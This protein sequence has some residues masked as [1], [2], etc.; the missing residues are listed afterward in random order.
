[1]NKSNKFLLL[2]FLP[3]ILTVIFV[4]YV[5][6]PSFDSLKNAKSD[7]ADN[8]TKLNELK[9]K[10]AG[11]KNNK[12]NLLVI[13][14]LSQKLANF[15]QQVSED[16]DSALLVF[17]SEKLADLSK[18]QLL[19][20]SIKDELSEEELPILTKNNSPS[21]TLPKAKLT[22]LVSIPVEI[23]IQGNYL[24]VID[25]IINV[26]SYQRKININTLEIK[27]AEKSSKDKIQA[28]LNCSFYK[29]KKN[30]ALEVK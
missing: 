23:N 3:V 7:F 8:S 22:E 15:E 5:L 17:D 27:R 2:S 28:R 9:N 14:K 20:F 4:L 16:Y 1:M 25:F 6:I 19:S 12:E 13:Q 21:S 11:A 10:V 24:R 30:K 29:V 26:E 18:V